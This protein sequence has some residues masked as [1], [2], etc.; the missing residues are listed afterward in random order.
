M[1][2]FWKEAPMQ[3]WW[4]RSLQKKGNIYIFGACEEQQIPFKRMGLYGKSTSQETEVMN[5]ANEDNRNKGMYSAFIKTICK[6][7]VRHVNEQ[8]SMSKIALCALTPGVRMA[9]KEGSEIVFQVGINTVNFT[10][11]DRSIG[12]VPSKQPEWPYLWLWKMAGNS[13]PV[14]TCGCYLPCFKQGFEEVPRSFQSH[15]YLN[16][17]VRW[18]QLHAPC[19]RV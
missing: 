10:A 13:V 8:K 4:I 12:Q 11:I 17:T 2:N 16:D 1:V 9:V 18:Y 15:V 14:Q 6:D 7:Q 19:F 5:N 3:L